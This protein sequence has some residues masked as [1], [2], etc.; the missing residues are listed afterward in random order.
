M[1]SKAFITKMLHG[2]IKH[3]ATFTTITHVTVVNVLLY[4]SS[5]CSILTPNPLHHD[6]TL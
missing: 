4:K 2:D 6:V 5:Q 3:S 1:A